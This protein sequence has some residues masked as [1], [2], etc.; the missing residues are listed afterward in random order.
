MEYFI[1]SRL[2]YSRTSV[3]WLN[4]R[5]PKV[6][7]FQAAKSGSISDGQ[8]DQFLLA[9]HNFALELCL[10]SPLFKE[11]RLEA[12]ENPKKVADT[13]WSHPFVVEERLSL[14]DLPPVEIEN[15]IQQFCRLTKQRIT[16]GSGINWRM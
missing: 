9:I 1:H 12:E 8:V 15:I 3:G 7:Q 13:L 5:Q 4:F 14:P 2:A 10:P 11:F 16:I 6:A